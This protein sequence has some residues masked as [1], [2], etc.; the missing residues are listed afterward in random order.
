[1]SQDPPRSVGLILPCAI[2]ITFPTAILEPPM[3]RVACVKPGFQSMAKTKKHLVALDKDPLWCKTAVIY[4]CHV[5]AFCDSDGDEIGDFKGLTSKLAYLQ[6]L[7]VTALCLQPFYS[8]SLKDDGYE[9]YGD[10]MLLAEADHFSF[11][12]PIH[13]TRSLRRMSGASCNAW[14][15]FSIRPQKNKDYRDPRRHVLHTSISVR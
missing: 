6:S 12:P 4:R 1:M 7:G 10:R 8:S 3:A 2:A 14:A 9:K 5:H 13:Y 11:G 15:R